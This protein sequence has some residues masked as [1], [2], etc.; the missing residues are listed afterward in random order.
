MAGRGATGRRRAGGARAERQTATAASAS[1]P[2]GAT[3]PSSRGSPARQTSS[4]VRRRVL[5]SAQRAERR[6]QLV[7][8]QL[9]LF[10]GR[11]VA[12][13]VELVVVDEFGIRPLCPAPRGLIELVWK[14]AH[15]DRRRNSQR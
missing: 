11:E 2:V 15:G 1:R 14:G 9:G 6:A 3:P 4:G 5:R 13:S 7:R 12:A 10:P 8:E